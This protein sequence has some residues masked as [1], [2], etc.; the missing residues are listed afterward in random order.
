MFKMK[1]KKKNVIF[2]G[3][4]QAIL[5]GKLPKIANSKKKLAQESFQ[6]SMNALIKT[7]TI[8]DT[9]LHVLSIIPTSFEVKIIFI[10]WDLKSQT[11]FRFVVGVSGLDIEDLNFID[12]YP[13]FSQ[14]VL[15]DTWYVLK[16]DETQ[17]KPVKKTSFLFFV[18]ATLCL[19][20]ILLWASILGHICGVDEVINSATQ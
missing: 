9:F 3:K 2:F 5:R 7:N 10:L 11:F 20:F 1:K 14:P 8:Q 12:S 13:L 15:Y 18:A 19:Y 4:I 6:H 17:P 16:I